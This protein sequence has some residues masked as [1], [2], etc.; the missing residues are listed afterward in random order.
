MGIEDGVRW[1]RRERVLYW[2]VLRRKEN[3]ERKFWGCE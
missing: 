1:Y 2:K 3:F